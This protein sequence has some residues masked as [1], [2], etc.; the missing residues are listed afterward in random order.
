VNVIR[1]ELLQ[2]DYNFP[3][4]GR[5]EGGHEIGCRRTLIGCRIPRGK[6][7]DYEYRQTIGPF[8]PEG[9]A[10]DIERPDTDF[11]NE[12]SSHRCTCDELPPWR[13]GVLYCEACHR[14]LSDEVR[15]NTRPYVCDCGASE[16]DY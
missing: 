10:I 15:E 9:Y 6:H 11:L 3:G 12:N 4:E 1:D 7:C 5:C 16:E 8:G 14:M 13:D 2:R